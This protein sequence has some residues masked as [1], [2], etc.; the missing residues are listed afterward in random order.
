MFPAPSVFFIKN[1]PVLI[2]ELR[3]IFD[4]S[5]RLS[6][7]G[8]LLQQRQDTLQVVLG[9]IGDHI[10]HKL[11]MGDSGERVLDPIMRISYVKRAKSELGS[12]GTMLRPDVCQDTYS[13]VT[14]SV[15]LVCMSALVAG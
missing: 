2:T 13:P 3:E 9:G 11:V 7:Q 14:F 5:W 12:P 1:A 10:G 4:S 15:I 6:S 8:A